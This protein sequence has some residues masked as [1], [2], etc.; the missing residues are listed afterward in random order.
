MLSVGILLTVLEAVLKTAARG[1][2][3]LPDGS[4]SSCTPSTLRLLA[5]VR[6][7]LPALAI[8]LEQRL[9]STGNGK[10]RHLPGPPF[11]PANKTWC[12]HGTPIID[13]QYSYESP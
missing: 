9:S 2:A 13:N 10:A 5:A 4:Q 7:A 11:T 6:L 1:I 3:V 8:F 12:E